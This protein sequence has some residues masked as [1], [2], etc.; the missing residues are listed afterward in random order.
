MGQLMTSFRPKEDKAWNYVRPFPDVAP[1]LYFAPRGDNVFEV[2]V[3]DGWKSKVTSNSDDP[4]N[5]FHTS[6]LFTPHPTIP[7]AWKYLSRNDDRITL[8]NGEKVLPVPFE[9]HLRRNPLVREALLFGVDKTL[10]GLLIIPSERTGNM[11][12]ADLLDAIWPS[13][14]EA[15]AKVES[16]SQISREMVEILDIHVDYPATDKGTMIRAAS[17][18][19]F[20]SLIEAVYA[21][22]EGTNDSQAPKLQLSQTDLEEYVLKAVEDKANRRLAVD[23]DFFN[24][25]IDSL[26]ATTIRAFLKRSLDTGENDLGQNIIFEYPNARRLAE[27]LYALR[28]G[29]TQEKESEI[30][31]MQELI[32][33]YS[34]FKKH[35]PVVREV[36]LLSGTTGGLGAHILSQLLACPNVEQVYCPVRASSPSA[37]FDR[38][39]N[40]LVKKGLSEFSNVHKIIALPADF[41]KADLGLSTENLA[42]IRTSLTKVIHSAWAVNFNLGVRSFEQ[43]HIQGVSN[44]INLCL[45]VERPE[46]AQFYFCSSISVAAATPLPATIAEAPIPELAHAQNMGYARSKVVAEKIIQSAAESTGMIAKVLRVGQI[47]GDS[48]RGIWN[49]T[50]AIPLMIQ[51]A[52]TMGALPALEEV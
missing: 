8:V 34:T 43:Q 26:Q 23:D 12:H 14:F 11:S 29:S 7:N 30:D 20:A 1:F 40:T 25:G 24:A 18:K 35:T 17:Y 51:S 39:L 44:L 13:I 16:F 27:H 50:E 49:T 32:T 28:T 5:S 6:D 52:A 9:N 19:K 46:P 42:A 15:N 21:R 33:K 45:S 31:V 48:Q 2:V 3:L 4:P 37:A 38:V 36:V 22:F 41:S 10:P 47:V